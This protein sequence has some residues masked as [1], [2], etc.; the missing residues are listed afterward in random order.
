MEEGRSRKR[1]VRKL[2]QVQVRLDGGLIPVGRV[3]MDPVDRPNLESADE[4]R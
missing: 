3:K 2:E 1:E 4:L